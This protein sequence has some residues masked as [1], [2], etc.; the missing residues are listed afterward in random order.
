M[1]QLT[2]YNQQSVWKRWSVIAVFMILTLM[3]C[4]II[5][6]FSSQTADLSTKSS[7]VIVDKLEFVPDV[8]P[9][10]SSQDYDGITLTYLVRKGAHFYNFAFLG[11]LLCIDKNIIKNGI[12]FNILWAAVGLFVAAFDEI[13]QYFVPGRSAEFVDVMIDF[14]GALFGICIMEITLSLALKRRHNGR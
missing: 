2:V 6:M 13:H 4:L 1:M 3:Q 5:T 10:E 8:I 11:A 9:R 14:S 7:A 12:R